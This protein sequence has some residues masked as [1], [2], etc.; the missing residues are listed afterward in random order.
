MTRPP[1]NPEDNPTLQELRA[2]R[3]EI[4]T[5]RKGLVHQISWGMF[6]AISFWI[7]LFVFLR[8]FLGY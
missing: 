7:L 6:L 1:R 5:L 2:I 3:K 8:S 4:E